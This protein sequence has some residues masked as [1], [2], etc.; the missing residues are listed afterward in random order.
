MPD[1]PYNVRSASEVSARKLL[2]QASASSPSGASAARRK[3]RHGAGAG[4]ASAELVAPG[5]A[6][7]ILNVSAVLN[8]MQNANEREYVAAVPQAVGNDAGG[9]AGAD[10]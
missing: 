5:T 6:D 10:L 9:R 1:M 4:A 8:Q 2:D 3:D 7:D